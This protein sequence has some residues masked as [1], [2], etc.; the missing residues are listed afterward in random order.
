MFNRPVHR[1][2]GKT[3]FPV[4]KALSV[5]AIYIIENFNK[6]SARASA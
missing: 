5:T 1:R 2:I 3:V 4:K 6:M